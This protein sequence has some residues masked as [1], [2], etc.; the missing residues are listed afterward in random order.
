[1]DE[2]HR[3][4]EATGTGPPPAAAELYR[5]M[6]AR[7][8]VRA[9]FT[10][11]PVDPQVLHRVLAAGHRAPSVGNTQPWDF[12]VVRQPERLET[13][14]RHVRRCRLD[15]AASLPADRAAVFDPIKVEG[16][17]ES[18]T[19]VVVTY[20]PTRGGEHVLGRRTVDDTGVFSAVLAIQNMWL[21]ATAEGLGMGWVSFYEEDFL[22][23][24]VGV[25]PPVRPIAWLC[26]GPVERLQ[27]VPDLVRHGWRGTRPLHEAVHAERW[28]AT[29]SPEADLEPG[30]A[31]Q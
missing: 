23:R 13:F 25:R 29:G 18:G 19:G 30:T 14:A 9:E 17:R 12:V 6:S 28:G 3:P 5:V 21:A 20:D 16:V 15:F 4:V 26:L 22:A 2:G 11:R 10:G 24:F 8:D 27:E 7:R 1:M 31:R